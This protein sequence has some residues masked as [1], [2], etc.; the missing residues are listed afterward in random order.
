MS[1]VADREDLKKLRSL[2]EDVEIGMLTTS[3]DG[4][5]LRSRPMVTA[6]VEPGGS[7]WFFTAF[8][9]PK[10]DQIE[11]DAAVNVAYSE[12]KSQTYVSVSGRAKVRRD[13]DKIDELWSPAA[14]AYFPEGKD[15]PN[16]AL[17]EV[18]IDGAEYWDAK[19]SRMVQLFQ[20][21]KGA[22]TGRQPDMGES[23]KMKINA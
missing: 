20:M 17:L 1:Q 18:T 23:R 21:A 3:T 22:M 5:S 10:V 14:K 15:D 11:A 13:R 9:A 12:P 8:D 16:L 6:Q 19:R 4:G 7:L 2:I